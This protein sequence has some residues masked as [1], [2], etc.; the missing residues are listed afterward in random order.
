MERVLPA[1]LGSE[2]LPPRLPEEEV[3][4]STR[5]E[6]EKSGPKVRTLAAMRPRFC[7]RL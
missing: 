5:A 4:K 3:D 1:R 2:D 6:G 7:S